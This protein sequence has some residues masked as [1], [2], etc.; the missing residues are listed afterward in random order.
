MV[1]RR[2]TANPADT[3]DDAE[4]ARRHSRITPT[5][6]WRFTACLSSAESRAGP[7]SS[8]SGMSRQL[9]VTAAATKRAAR[10]RRRTWSSWRRAANTSGATT[11]TIVFEMAAALRAAK[12]DAQRASIRGPDRR[13]FLHIGLARSSPCT[14]AS[15][16][17]AHAR[18]TG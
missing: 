17:D 12:T 14:A 10:S 18:L 1:T 11:Q 6:N 16:S 9:A 5:K 8:R 4:N 3:Q 2:K 13:L 7:A 15:P